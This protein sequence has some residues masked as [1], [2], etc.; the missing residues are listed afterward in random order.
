[1]KNINKKNVVTIVALIIFICGIA[2][3]SI[4]YSKFEKV[5]SDLDKAK[6]F[7]KQAE[8]DNEKI[9]KKI[10]AK[11]IGIYTNGKANSI[12]LPIKKEL[13]YIFTIAYTYNSGSDYTANRRELKNIISDKS[14]F[15]KY[16]TPDKD[17]SGKSIVDT[18]G[19]KSSVQNVDVYS[20]DKNE[21]LV[22][23]DYKSKSANSMT[24]NKEKAF[25]V[26][27]TLH[28]YSK[29]SA[30]SGMHMNNI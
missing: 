13:K 24:Q 20:I 19:D 16:Y 30:I 17:V 28:D 26:N 1:M 9:N 21:Y 8:K 22:I 23:V 29:V 10:N 2:S 27:G 18:R 6:N 14:F 15:E 3:V 4:S 5:K 7:N 12:N 11:E 25:T